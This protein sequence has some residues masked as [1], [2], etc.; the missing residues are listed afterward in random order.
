MSDA[1]L[2]RVKDLTSLASLNLHETQVS[3][4][5]LGLLAGLTRLNDLTL[6]STEIGDAGLAHLNEMTNLWKLYLNGDA[7]NGRGPGK[8]ARFEESCGNL[9]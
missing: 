9:V 2:A 7:G 3:D 1:G 5:G 4:A 8:V 6:S